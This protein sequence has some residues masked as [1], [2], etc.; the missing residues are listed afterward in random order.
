MCYILCN[1]YEVT[2]QVLQLLVSVVKSI[3]KSHMSQTKDIVQ[4]TYMCFVLFCFVL[5]V[6]FVCLF[7]C[8]FVLSEFQLN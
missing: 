4:N 8:L 5:F 7:V 6:L 3:Q 2:L 1:Y